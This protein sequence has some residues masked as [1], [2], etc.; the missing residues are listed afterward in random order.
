MTGTVSDPPPSS[1]IAA[2][3]GGGRRAN[4][5]G[6]RQWHG[7]DRDGAHAKL[8]D[9]TYDVQVTATDIAGNSGHDTTTN[10]LIVDTVKPTVTVDTQSWTNNTM[11]TLTGTVSDPEPSSGI[12]GNVTVV[13]QMSARRSDADGVDQSGDTHMARGGA[14]CAGRWDLRRHGHGHGQRLEH[15]AVDTRSGGVVD[16]SKPTVTVESADDE[17]QASRLDRDGQRCRAQ[18]RDFRG[19]GR[20]RHT[21]ADGGGR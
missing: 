1:G 7:L 9:G 21:D 16:T 4:A 13:A 18:Q 20:G 5:D 17:Q 12:S 15:R 14:D 6:D 2:G 8:A 19:D 3:D 10:E 11:P